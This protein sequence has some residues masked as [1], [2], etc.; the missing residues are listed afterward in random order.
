MLFLT[1]IEY[2]FVLSPNNLQFLNSSSHDHAIC[3]QEKG[4]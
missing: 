3:R 1:Q 2:I 4:K